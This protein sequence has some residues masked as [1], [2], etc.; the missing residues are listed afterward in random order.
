MLVPCN[1]KKL[2]LYSVR[3]FSPRS[4]LIIF[5][6]GVTTQNF[7]FFAQHPTCTYNFFSAGLSVQNA[8]AFSQQMAK[9]AGSVY[10]RKMQGESTLNA[11]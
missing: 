8:S 3:V 9:P 11:I 1:S 6:L 5:F 2:F 4:A 10:K 7:V